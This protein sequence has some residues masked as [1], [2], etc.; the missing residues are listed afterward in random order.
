MNGN[1]LNQAEINSGSV[2][3]KGVECVLGDDNLYHPI[4]DQLD[5][6]VYEDEDLETAYEPQVAVAES[7]PK[8]RR[9]MSLPT[10]LFMGAAAVGVVVAPAAVHMATEQAANFFLDMAKPTE[11]KAITQDELTADL[12]K[13]FN[14][15]VTKNIGRIIEG[16]R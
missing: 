16:G 15:L 5:D 2:M 3:I 1:Y 13:S 7:K 6:T 12:S 9:K 4:G 8:R 11:D 10:R 14:E